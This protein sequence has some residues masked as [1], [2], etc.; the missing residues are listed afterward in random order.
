[1]AKQKQE[2]ARKQ[3][4]RDKHRLEEEQA[5]QLEELE[6]NRQKLVEAKLTELELADDLSQA[7]DELCETLSQISKH[8]KQ[9]RREFL[10]GWLMKPTNPIVLQINHRPIPLISTM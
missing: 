6:K 2:A 9:R 5:V 8:S 10:T 1:M 7:T 3:L 4:E